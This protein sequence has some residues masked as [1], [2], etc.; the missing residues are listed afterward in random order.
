MY[1]ASRMGDYDL[2]QSLL[3]DGARADIETNSRETPLLAA[4]EYGHVGIVRVLLDTQEGRL[5]VNTAESSKGNTALHEAVK[6]N[7]SDIVRILLGCNG[8]DVNKQNSDHYPACMWGLNICEFVK[9]VT[10]SKWR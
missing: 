4:S 7:N 10:F 6:K 8:T 5:S 2:V 1:W 9:Q 3:K